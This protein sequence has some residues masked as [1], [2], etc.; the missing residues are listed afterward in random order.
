MTWTWSSVNPP[1][2]PPP[3]PFEASRSSRVP[4]ASYAARR[5]FVPRTSF[6]AFDLAVC[7]LAGAGPAVAYNMRLAVGTD[8]TCARVRFKV[9]GAPS[10]HRICMGADLH[11]STWR[12]IESTGAGLHM[13]TVQPGGSWALRSLGILDKT[14]WGENGV[15]AC[16]RRLLRAP[17]ARQAPCHWQAPWARQAPWVRLGT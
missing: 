3:L 9:G 7:V 5:F 4:A 13:R 2:E 10:C 11:G 8:S 12:L 17:W 16:R 14:E 1:A 6:S 15:L